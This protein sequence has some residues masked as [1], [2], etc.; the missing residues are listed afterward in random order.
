MKYNDIF[1]AFGFEDTEDIGRNYGSTPEEDTNPAV[2][3]PPAR[4]EHHEL[5]Q[6]SDMA[7][8]RLTMEGPI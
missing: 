5:P 1:K 4:A 3:Q 6:I 2:E 8:E 7:Y